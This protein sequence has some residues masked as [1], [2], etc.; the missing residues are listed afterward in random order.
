MTA[1]SNPTTREPLAGTNKTESEKGEVIHSLCAP[2]LVKISENLLIKSCPNLRISKVNTLRFIAKNTTIPVPKVHDFQNKG[3]NV[4]KITMDFMPGKRLQDAWETMNEAQKTS[5][6][7]QL[8][9]YVEQIRAYSR[10]GL[11]PL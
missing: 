11:P 10:E 4:T 8:R 9:S 6:A 2:K 1:A 3:E 5:V 7:E